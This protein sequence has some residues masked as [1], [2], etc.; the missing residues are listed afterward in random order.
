MCYPVTHVFKVCLGPVSVDSSCKGDCFVQRCQTN[1]IA[2]EYCILHALDAL[3]VPEYQ[4]A[5]IMPMENFY[6]VQEPIIE[7]APA[8]MDHVDS[9]VV[10][11]AY[12]QDVAEFE[13]ICN[14]VAEDQTVVTD[15]STVTVGDYPTREDFPGRWVRDLLWSPSEADIELLTQPLEIEAGV[16]WPAQEQH[17]LTAEEFV[18]RPC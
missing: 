12:A 4:E 9:V 15:W 2:D 5:E 11:T 14:D 1:F 13:V 17:F 8:E 7:I 3:G 18:L 10:N 16:N 6:T